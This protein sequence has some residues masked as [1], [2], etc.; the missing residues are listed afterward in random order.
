V[1]SVL[2]DD[3]GHTVWLSVASLKR[4]GFHRSQVIPASLV[5]ISAKST[6]NGAGCLHVSNWITLV[7]TNRR[8]RKKDSAHSHTDINWLVSW[9]S[10]SVSLTSPSRLLLI[11]RKHVQHIW[12]PKFKYCS[13]KLN[14]FPNPT[15]QLAHL[16][17]NTSH[18]NHPA[19]ISSGC[20]SANKLNLPT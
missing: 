7:I 6:L 10:L 5:H 4:W 17:E 14:P 20:I 11:Y 19:Q 13:L 18:V 12:A 2:Q 8:V 16:L 15:P 9:I 1:S 3:L